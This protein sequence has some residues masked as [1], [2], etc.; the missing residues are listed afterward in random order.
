MDESR[1]HN[2]DMGSQMAK[3]KK[4]KTK[5]HFEDALNTFKEICCAKSTEFD[6]FGERVSAQ[7]KSLPSREA[8]KLQL[9]IQQLITSNKL[10]ILD[11]EI[12]PTFS[13]FRPKENCPQERSLSAFIV[14]RITSSSALSSSSIRI[15]QPGNIK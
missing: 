9:Q 7:L 8:I 2:A 15:L 13:A 14:P 5:T 12:P 4:A 6:K 11:N 10:E 1:T 3:R